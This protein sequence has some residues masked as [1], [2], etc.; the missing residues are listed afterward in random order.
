MEKT[1]NKKNQNP[2]SGFR[3]YL[4]KISIHFP[5]LFPPPSADRLK[6]SL[7]LFEV[8]MDWI[9]SMSNQDLPSGSKI[10]W[11]PS[12]KKMLDE[13]KIASTLGDTE[14]GWR[15]LK[16]ADRFLY[17]GLAEVA[18]ELLLAKEKTII[19]E[20][21]DEIKKL[22]TWRKN[23]IN[24]LLPEKTINDLL[25]EKKEESLNEFKLII[26]QERVNRIVEAKKILDEHFDNIYQKQT[27]I[28]S[29][30]NILFYLGGL[31]I[32]FW[33]IANPPVPLKI[34]KEDPFNYLVNHSLHFW[35]FVVLSGCLGAILSSFTDTISNFGKRSSIPNELSLG[36][37]LLSRLMVGAL[38]SIAVILILSAD[39]L[40]Y[41]PDTVAMV[42]TLAFV[43]GF[44][45][46]F[47]ASAIGK[48]L[49]S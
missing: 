18:P 30:L 4:R 9:V 21:N 19:K 16:A 28:K 29:R 34:D 23:T 24:D 5:K 31:L 25:P 45:D 36:F 12:A 39:I 38:S 15:C 13:A 2:P 8:E 3:S 27:I 35:W 10:S 46:R 42:L 33:F 22:S 41:K 26:T 20:A 32:I 17:Y 43:S 40:S 44:S 48:M 11:K 1:D 49:N 14:K 47:L 7:S 6:N 37:L